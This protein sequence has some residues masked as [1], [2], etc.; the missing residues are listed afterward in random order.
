MRYV[1]PV[2]ASAAGLLAAEQEGGQFLVPV[3]APAHEKV[4]QDAFTRVDVPVTLL[5]GM[6]Y[7]ALQLASAAAVC[8]GTATLEFTCLGIPM[9]IVY[10]ASP[11]TTLQ[12]LLLRGLLARQRRAGMPN[13]LAGRDVVPELIWRQAT[14][15]AIAETVGDLLESEGGRERM[16]RDL[17]EVTSMLG[18]GDA[19]DRTAELV[20]QMVAQGDGTRAPA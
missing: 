11:G 9:A 20:L 16:R 4:V 2:L 3:A 10:R 13:I 8:S 1:L 17:Q 18:P 7:S 6:D 5:R 12:F 19:S 14:P 15:E